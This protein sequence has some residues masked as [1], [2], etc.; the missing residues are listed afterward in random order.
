[1][2]LRP[3]LQT[4]TEVQDVKLIHAVLQVSML[5]ARYVLLHCNL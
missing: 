4:A 1:M 2:L 5:A 3:D